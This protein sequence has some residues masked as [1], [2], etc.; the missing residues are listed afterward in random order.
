MPPTLLIVSLSAVETTLF[1][2]IIAKYTEGFTDPLLMTKKKS[3]RCSYY[4]L[5]TL[6]SFLDERVPIPPPLGNMEGAPGHCDMPYATYTVCRVCPRNK[7]W[8]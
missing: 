7:N 6:H 2:F 1:I 3:G 4:T 8:M 5:E